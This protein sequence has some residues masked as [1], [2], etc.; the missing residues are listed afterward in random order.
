MTCASN[1]SRLAPTVRPVT[2]HT[3]NLVAANSS[4]D[5]I[6]AQYAKGLLAFL[7][8]RLGEAPWA[9]D[10]LHDVFMAYLR[11]SAAKPIALP[12]A[13]LYRCANRL[14]LNAL[15]DRAAEKRNASRVAEAFAPAPGADPLLAQA[16]FE[17]LAGLPREE[18]EVVCLRVFGGL[19][20]AEISATLGQPITNLF[21]RYTRGLEALRRALE[22]GT[23]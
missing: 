14:S 12:R 20:F 2:A 1:L 16:A 4:L 21:K 7:C 22:E 8:A 11:H 17:A 9:E 5:E 23:S 15:R 3:A 13:F 6:Y 18:R 10:L 19:T